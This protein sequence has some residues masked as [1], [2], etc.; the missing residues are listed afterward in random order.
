MPHLNLDLGYFSN[1][2][3]KRLIGL[4]GRGAEVLP[5]RL[6]CY[7]GMHHA[8][9]GGLTDYTPQE[10][11]SIAEWWGKPGEMVSAM[12]RVGLLEK[13]KS[14][15]F[16][17]HDW[18]ETQGHLGAFQRRAKA[19]AAAR[20]GRASSN[21]TSNASSNARSVDEQ[22]PNQPTNQLASIAGARGGPGEAAD[23]DPI[24]NQVRAF[25]TS[26]PMVEWNARNQSDLAKLVRAKGWD[27]AKKYIAKGIG[28]R[29]PFPIG[30]AMGCWQKDEKAI[31]GG[32]PK[33]QNGAARSAV[34]S[35][36]RRDR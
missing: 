27:Y 17:I 24:E 15:G 36:G 19:A 33:P 5:I 25:L 4:L 18:T 28:E 30:Y 6:W 26:E 12:V 23:G 21:A 34:A 1:R 8:E 9:S 16:A 13:L 31:A 7:C 29:A 10:I 20:W 22:S 2:K 14:G 35:P 3:V 32:A 11:E